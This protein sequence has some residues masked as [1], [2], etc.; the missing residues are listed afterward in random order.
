MSVERNSLLE[1]PSHA[2]HKED[3]SE[4]D[5]VSERCPVS[6]VNE[7]ADTRCHQSV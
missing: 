6:S 4:T 3:Y 7:V 2:K 5:Q 1:S